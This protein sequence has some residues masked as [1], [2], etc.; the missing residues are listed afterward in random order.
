MDRVAIR[1]RTSKAALYRRWSGR[2]ELVLDACGKRGILDVDVPDTGDLRT[3]VLDLLRQV[4]ARLATPIGGIVRGLLAETARDPELSGL[5]RERMHKAGPASIL[6]VLER[7][8]ERGEVDPSV[9]GSRRATVATEL[10]RNEFLLFGAPIEDA[11]I[12][13]IVDEVYL[14]LIRR[15]GGAAGG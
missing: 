3:D 13:D 6:A 15:S 5:L 8:V 12:I 7:A 4:A 1:S 10:L 14:P 11:S 2:A 9:L